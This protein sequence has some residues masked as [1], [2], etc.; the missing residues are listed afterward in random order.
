MSKKIS[1]TIDE[2]L[3]SYIDSQT[4]NRSQFISQ[5]VTE[6]KKHHGLEQLKKAYKEQSSDKEEANEIELW[7]CTVGDGLENFNSTW[8]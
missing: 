3:I 8:L 5:I 2:D 6:A 7:D 4:T 1:I